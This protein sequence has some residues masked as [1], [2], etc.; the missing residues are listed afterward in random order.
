MLLRGHLGAGKTVLAR[1]IAYGLGARSWRG[2]PTFALVHEYD[3]RPMLYHADMYR[4]NAVEVDELGLEDYVGPDSVT[5]VEWPDRHDSAFALLA[6]GRIF[7]I[8]MQYAA[9][10]VRTIDITAL[11]NPPVPPLKDPPP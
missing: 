10:D 6:G 11:D 8:R 2:S 1:G 7:D 5:V 3:T 4:L 9:G